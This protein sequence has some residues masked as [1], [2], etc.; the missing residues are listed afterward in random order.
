MNTSYFVLCLVLF[1]VGLAVLGA[2][3]LS[4]GKAKPLLSMWLILI[5]ACMAMVFMNICMFMML[6]AMNQ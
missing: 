3:A 5:G 6:G 2:G 4:R 1:F